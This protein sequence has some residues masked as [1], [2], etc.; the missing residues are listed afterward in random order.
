MFSR[1]ATCGRRRSASTKIVRIPARALAAESPTATV[2]FPSS[3]S[4]LTTATLAGRS[5][6]VE[7][8]HRGPEHLERLPLRRR[9]LRRRYRTRRAES[10]PAAAI[11]SASRDPPRCAD[12][13]SE[14]SASNTAP[15]PSRIAITSASSTA[16]LTCGPTGATFGYRGLD[17]LRPGADRIEQP[18]KLCQLAENR[19]AGLR[20]LS[21]PQ[22]RELALNLLL[23]RL[24][25]LLRLVDA[26]RAGERVRDVRRELRVTGLRADRHEASGRC[27][28]W[29]SRP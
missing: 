6:G 21:D 24:R 11:P 22:L 3:I 15:I 7:V 8:G 9:W 20:A 14:L 26:E 23:D 2:V 27:P 29:H 28:P 19:P 5:S 25:G 4:G 1:D 12:R 13:R 18:A 16:R 10:P 17:H